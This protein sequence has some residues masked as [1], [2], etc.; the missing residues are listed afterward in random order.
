MSRNNKNCLE[1]KK[2][3]ILNMKYEMSYLYYTL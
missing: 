1:I 3:Q 2:Y